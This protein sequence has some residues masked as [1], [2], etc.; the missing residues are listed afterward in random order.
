[1]MHLH[2]DEQEILVDVDVDGMGRVQVGVAVDDVA[3]GLGKS[4]G[5]GEQLRRRRD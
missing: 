4:M 2:R 1:M 5:R 3:S